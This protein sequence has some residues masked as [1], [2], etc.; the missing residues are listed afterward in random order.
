METATR[1][2]SAQSLRFQALLEE[3]CEMALAEGLA[4]KPYREGG[5]LFFPKLPEALQDS[6]LA[7]FSTYID[8]A[9]GVLAQG[10]SLKDDQMFLWH[11]FKKLRAHAPMDFLSHLASGEVIE[12]HNR[13][14]I[15]IYRNMHFFKLCTYTIEDL[16]CRPFWELYERDVAIENSLISVA[17]AIFQGESKG[18][19]QLD[20][21]E[22][23]VLEKDSEGR[24]LVTVQHR[25]AAPLCDAHGNII[26]VLAAVRTPAFLQTAFPAPKAIGKTLRE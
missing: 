3:F 9:R 25:I 17:S 7:H 1:V 2:L 8:A 20:I 14:F 6:T 13:D 18:V 19:S 10:G 26:A 16:I 21:P 4:L 15:Q 5:L 23:T 12:I 11:I 22:H 24:L